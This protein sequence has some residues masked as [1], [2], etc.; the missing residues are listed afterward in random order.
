MTFKDVLRNYRMVYKDF[1]QVEPCSNWLS[2]TST[3]PKLH[4]NLLGA[5]LDASIAQHGRLDVA[6]KQ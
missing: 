5:C 6:F 3:A 4:T 1:V 2:A